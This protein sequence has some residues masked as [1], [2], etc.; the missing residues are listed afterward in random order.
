MLLGNEGCNWLLGPNKLASFPG[1]LRWSKSPDGC[2]LYYLKRARQKR[3]EVAGPVPPT[4]NHF[5]VTWPD[6]N[7]TVDL[8][9]AEAHPDDLKR[10]YE[11]RSYTLHIIFTCH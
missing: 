1:Q 9:Y 10:L 5:T 2:I 6:E 4:G 3:D 7:T 11:V 8:L